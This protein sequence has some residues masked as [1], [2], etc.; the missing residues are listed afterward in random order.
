M[1]DKLNHNSL[2]SY[3]S[4][5]NLGLI[6]IINIFSKKSCAVTVFYGSRLFFKTSEIGKILDILKFEDPDEEDAP[7][8]MVVNGLNLQGNSE[9]GEGNHCYHFHL[10]QCFPNCVPSDPGRCAAGSR[11]NLF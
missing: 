1:E 8:L 9:K 6:L 7:F 10:Q 5:F 4:T 2:F 3:T 11:I